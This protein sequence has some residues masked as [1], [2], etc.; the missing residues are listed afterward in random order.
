M[1]LPAGQLI[2]DPEG[3]KVA[4]ASGAAFYDLAAPKWVPVRREAISSDGSQYAFMDATGLHTVN[5]KSGRNRLLLAD[6]AWEVV[7][8]GKDAVY[9]SRLVPSGNEADELIE[10]GLYRE[11]L[12][13]GPPAQL[14]SSRVAD[15][16]LF[17]E[18]AWALPID[19]HDYGP[20]KRLIRIDLRTGASETWYTA[21]GTPG[22]EQ[23]A[24]DNDGKPVVAIGGEQ[25]RLVK[26]DAKD[27]PRTLYEGPEYPRP[28]GSFAVDSRGLW[29]STF[30]GIGS[31]A[32]PPFLVSRGGHVVQLPSTDPNVV[33]VAGGC[34]QAPGFAGE[35]DLLD[36]AVFGQGLY[37]FASETRG[38]IGL[39]EDVVVGNAREEV[40]ALRR[41][42]LT[43]FELL[44]L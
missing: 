21:N 22:I 34:H 28:Q 12:T 32:S 8:F 35:L 6:A 11:P 4:R 19:E 39:A 25:V 38:V 13:G 29:L 37:V 43:S 17:G 3:T 10:S 33:T 36:D 23:L 26:V 7:E 44:A 41:Q 14:L 42:V 31:M 15:M 40:M 20:P 5:V 16:T 1:Q 24:I 2:E 9:L 27:R 18:Y 30:T